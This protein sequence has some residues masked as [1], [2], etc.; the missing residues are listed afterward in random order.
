M[1]DSFSLLGEKIKKIKKG[2]K[3][4]LCKNIKGTFNLIIIFIFILIIFIYSFNNNFLI[5]NTE[6]K[7][8]E[9]NNIKVNLN[10][11]EKNNTNTQEEENSIH[12]KE[13]QEKKEEPKREENLNKDNSSKIELEKTEIQEKEETSKKDEN[14]KKSESFK[15]EEL[16][17]NEETPKIGEIDINEEENQEN[18]DNN[19]SEENQKKKENSKKEKTPRNEE[20]F[21]KK[22]ENVENKG[23]ISKEEYQKKEEIPKISNPS[24]QLDVFQK[25]IKTAREGKILY[26][27]NLVECENPK[28]SVVIALYNAEKFIKPTLKSVQNQ[29][30]KDIEIIIVDDFSKDKSVEIVEEAKKIDPR[31]ILI[32]NKKNMAV[33]YTKSIGVLKAKGKYIFILDDDD[34]LLIDDLFD[35]IYEEIEKS[36]YDILEYSWIESTSFNLEEEY[37]NKKPICY[38]RRN[39]VLVQP[40]LRRSFSRENQ[41][42][43]ILPDRYVWGKLIKRDIYVKCIN[44]IG[45][46]DI[47]RRVII[48]D[49]TIITFMLLKFANSLK[50]LKKLD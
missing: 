7:N 41:G 4:L 27:E 38:H 21:P 12:K 40:K 5:R 50:K 46:Q 1:D 49:D 22:E 16:V 39:S 45:E 15:N 30:M 28:I 33:L 9:L 8:N 3:N 32:K 25:Y 20:D 36:Q 29:R 10:I 48:H 44:Q 37:I 35:T 19:E 34:L 2:K 43:F 31:I 14:S 24:F 26:E 47:T 17:N 11:T 23:K 42:F 6:V 18:E 13:I